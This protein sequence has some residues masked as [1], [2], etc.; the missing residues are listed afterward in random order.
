MPT[1]A[2][3]SVG[4]P[5]VAGAVFRAPKGT[6]LP[7]DASTALS[8]AF[9]DMGYVSEDGVTN[10]NEADSEEIKAWGGKTVLV[11]NTDSSDKFSLTLIES[12]NVNVLQSI[13]GSSNVTEDSNTHA[14]TINVS[15][16]CDEEAVWVIDVQMNANWMK[17][18]VIPCGML[19]E[20]G[21]VTY[22]DDEAIAYEIT[23]NALPDSSGNTHYEH[24]AKAS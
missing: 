24:M 14:I 10:A 15:G 2:N 11:V 5:K 19:S 22:K 9:K 7:T 20:L 18:I 13:F 8:D 6:T 21:D 12:T 1:I 17:R 16:L 4:K 3:V 23:I